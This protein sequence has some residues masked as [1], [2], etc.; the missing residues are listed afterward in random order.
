[1]G[2][3]FFRILSANG[4]RGLSVLR[5]SCSEVAAA[6]CKDSADI[7]IACPN[8]QNPSQETILVFYS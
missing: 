5:T 2:K 4:E 6:I 3:R 8:R 1:M 7:F